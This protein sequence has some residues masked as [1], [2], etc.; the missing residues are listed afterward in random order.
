MKIFKI[1]FIVSF[2]AFVIPAQVGFDRASAISQ[3]FFQSRSNDL[4][5]LDDVQVI[6][7]E[8]NSL[9]YVFILDPVGFVIVSGNDA[10][11]PILGY[12]FTN[13]FRQ[14]SMPI[15]LDLLFDEYQSDIAELY[16]NNSLPTNDI[17]TEWD[18]YANALIYEPS[19]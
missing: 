7:E 11:M 9:I 1:L 13:Q 3:N 8:G 5:L 14:D 2:L 17:R 16:N 18:R 4:Y 12:S 19:R 15:Q 10:A 6:S